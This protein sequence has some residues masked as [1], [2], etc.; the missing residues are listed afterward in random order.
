MKK[1]YKKRYKQIKRFVNFEIDLR[2][3]LTTAEKRRISL[4]Y[5]SISSI[6]DNNFQEYSTTNSKN[7]KK[8]LNTI[9]APSLP[10]AG[11]KRIPIK[12]DDKIKIRFDK[13]GNIKIKTGEF[14]E[15][16]IITLNN[17]RLV[18]DDAPEYLLKKFSKIKNKNAKNYGFDIYG[19]IIGQVFSSDKKL[20]EVFEDFVT[21]YVEAK[22][23]AR[24]SLQARDVKAPQHR[25]NFIY[26]R[27]KKI[28][29][30]NGCG[31]TR[32]A[33]TKRTY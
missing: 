12:S 29:E 22:P 6:T 32:K 5:N 19:N 18:M 9:A 14:I 15:R 25:H 33:K 2:K 21:K 17:K 3:K 13:K 10:K 7:F 30:C 31:M 16:T 20:L 1:D 24:F 27:K 23:A 28:Y 8:A 11:L 26:N 4:Y